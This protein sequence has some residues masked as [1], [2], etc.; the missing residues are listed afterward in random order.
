MSRVTPYLLYEDVAGALDWL[1]RA[2]GFRE[3]LRFQD[4]AGAITHAEM[5]LDGGEIML[6]HPGPDYRNPRRLG[7]TTQLVHVYVD[8]VDA[9][10]EKAREAGAEIVSEPKDQ[11][12]G[13]RRYDAKDPEGHLWSF[14][15]RM[16]EVSPDDWG[17]TEA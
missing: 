17:A 1:G 6:G 8:D 2:F 16:R 7:E 5:E 13:D 15:Q 12:Y 3:S 11:E 9:H 10:F 14:A 4:D